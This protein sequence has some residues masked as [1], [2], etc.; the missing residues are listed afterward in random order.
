VNFTFVFTFLNVMHRS[1]S[2]A[3]FVKLGIWCI[4]FTV[5]N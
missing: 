4:Q 2:T 1:V 5:T 3:G